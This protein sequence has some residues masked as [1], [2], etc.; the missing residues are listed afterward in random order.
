MKVEKI[1]NL[2]EQLNGIL[3]RP[4][5]VSVLGAID[6]ENGYVI[7]LSV[8]ADGC[9]DPLVLMLPIEFGDPFIRLLR[10]KIDELRAGMTAQRV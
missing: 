7:A 5:Q 8:K 4:D 2:G 6:G 3:L 9:E 10:E 1:G